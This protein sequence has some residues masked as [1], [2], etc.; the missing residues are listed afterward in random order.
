VGTAADKTQAI[1]WFDKACRH[2]IASSCFS[3]SAMYSA[4]NDA[5]KADQRLRQGCQIFASFAESSAAYYERGMLA[6]TVPLPGT[7][8]SAV[9]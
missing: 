3:A 9:R 1:E 5:N 4:L 6:K 8:A 7:C 2:G